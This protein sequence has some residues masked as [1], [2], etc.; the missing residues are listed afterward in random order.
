M[1]LRKHG[2]NRRFPQLDAQAGKILTKFFPEFSK[3]AAIRRPTLPTRRKKRLARHALS[4]YPTADD[5]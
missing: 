3:K 2:Q 4:D 1:G 5:Y